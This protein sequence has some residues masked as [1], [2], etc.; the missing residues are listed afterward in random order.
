MESAIVAGLIFIVNIIFLSGF[1]Y[2]KVKNSV[3][4]DEMSIAVNKEVAEQL[5]N[6]CPFHNDIKELKDWKKTHTEWGEKTQLKTHD[7]LNEIKINLKIV[8]ES[9]GVKYQTAN[10]K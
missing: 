6:H 9:L 2:Y 1:W 8:C 5:A 10:G 4:K 7:D 3:T